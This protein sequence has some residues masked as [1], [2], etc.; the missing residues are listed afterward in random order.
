MTEMSR[1]YASALFMLAKENGEKDEYMKSLEHISKV[2]EEMPEY[3]DFLASPAVALSE[4]TEKFKEAF[5]S[6]VPE[7]V[8]SFVSLL[9]ERGRIREFFSCVKEYKALYEFSQN[10]SVAKIKSAVPL[11]E[12]EKEKVT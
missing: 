6:S 5:S 8:V 1:E 2:F 12:T 9:C 3:I 11:T 4:R 10:V 7:Y